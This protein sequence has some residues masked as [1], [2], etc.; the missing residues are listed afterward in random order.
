M[1]STIQPYPA[2]TQ[3]R[4]RPRFRGAEEFTCELAYVW[5][6]NFSAMSDD[7][8]PE[9]ISARDLYLKWARRYEG[10]LSA[11]HPGRYVFGEISISWYI[12]SPDKPTR[13]FEAAPGQQHEPGSAGIGEDF[14]THFT[15][16]VHAET[17]EP[18]NW[19]RLPVENKGWNAKQSD[20]GGFVQEA[21]GWK[22]A[23][24][25]HTMNAAYLAAMAGIA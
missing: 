12:A 7:Y 23:P 15:L 16:P 22:P 1:S 11:E 20:K 25:Q 18:L 8:L 2:G 5:E 21:L 24:L 14:R 10:H 19:L 4:L 9:D 6:A 17:G 13:V 3:W